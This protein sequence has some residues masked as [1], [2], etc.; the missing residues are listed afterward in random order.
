MREALS[1]RRW[2]WM[3]CAALGL[4]IGADFHLVVPTKVS[5]VTNLYMTEPAS[6][7]LGG[8]PDDI[9]LLNTDKVL[10]LAYSYL[11]LRPGAPQPGSYSATAQSDVILQ[12][13]ASA[14]NPA[15]ATSWA[16]ALVKAFFVVRDKELGSQ[17]AL[18]V[19]VLQQ[20][21]NQLEANISKLNTAIK[22]LSSGP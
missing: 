17:T 15:E 6:A 19:N 12:V 22:A 16:N 13:T 9:S 3:A 21:V 8:M 4:V 7:G 10:S 20:Q 14:P 11:H 2:F 5:A 18:L 1:R